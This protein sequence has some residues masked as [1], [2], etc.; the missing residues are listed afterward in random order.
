MENNNNNKGESFHGCFKI[1]ENFVC[2]HYFNTK[3]KKNKSEYTLLCDMN[4]F[5]TWIEG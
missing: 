2:K 3:G 1:I 4:M 5:L